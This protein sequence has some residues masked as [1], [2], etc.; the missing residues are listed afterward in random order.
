MGSG[1]AWLAAG[2]GARR[3]RSVSGVVVCCAACAL[4]LVLSTLARAWA[5]S[6]FRD[7]PPFEGA[8]SAAPIPPDYKVPEEF[9]FGRLM[10]PSNGIFGGLRD[11]KQGDSEWTIDYPL[12]DRNFL[13]ILRRLTTIHARSVEQPVDPDDGDDIYNWP[14]I[15]IDTPGAMNLTDAQIAKLREYLLRGG[16]LLCDSF[17]GTPEWGPFAVT[18][19]R[20][21]PNRQPVELSNDNPIFH[22]V[23]DLTQRYQV[24]NE[25]SMR[26]RGVG[27]RW[28]GAVPHWL[29]V[30]DDQGR[31]M[32]MI[33]YNNDMGDAWQYA[34]DPAYPQK[35]VDLAIRLGI[36]IVV[37]DM[38]H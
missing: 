31:I 14:F 29:G 26:G 30:L 5:Q 32:I 22:T 17:F 36:N 7:Y 8:E 21:F 9:V 11:W 25:R 10:Y 16:F 18:L 12:G 19:H 24:R 23:Y 37:Y 34:D 27:Y 1:C 38:T 13:R 35:D 28:D 4:L 3:P 6:P 15:Y 20:L 33:M 2:L